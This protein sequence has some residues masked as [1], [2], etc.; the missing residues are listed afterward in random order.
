MHCV[1]R[2]Q[3]RSILPTL[4]A[5]LNNS[6]LSRHKNSPRVQHT[7]ENLRTFYRLAE[8][9]GASQ[10]PRS[11]SIF[12]VVHDQ[13]ILQLQIRHSSSTSSLPWNFQAV[14]IPLK[15]SSGI[16]KDF[17]EI[18]MTTVTSNTEYRLVIAESEG[19]RQHLA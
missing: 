3:K 18:T 5:I 8:L 4:L 19:H 7:S 17:P 12:R 14:Q 16:S 9:C 10:I 2:I 11:P 6:H 1:I 15:V 13:L